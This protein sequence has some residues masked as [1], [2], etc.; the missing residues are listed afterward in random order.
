MIKIKFDQRDLDE[1]KRFVKSMAEKRKDAPTKVVATQN[2]EL[3]GILGEIAF[4]KY[5]DF[6]TI[7]YKY[8]T[9]ELFNDP[10]NKYGDSYDFLIQGKYKIDVKSSG[11]YRVLYTDEKNKDKAIEN[12]VLI[13]GVY[14]DVKEHSIEPAEAEIIGVGK[15]T[16]FEYDPIRSTTYQGKERRLYIIPDNKTRKLKFDNEELKIIT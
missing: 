16:D 5:L 2:Y 10:N 6:Y 7:P 11:K 14:V 3:I 1:A 9:K 15:A 13:I 12:E 8:K 4:R